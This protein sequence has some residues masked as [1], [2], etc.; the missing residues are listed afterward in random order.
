MIYALVFGL[1]III[2]GGAGFLVLDLP[3]N[4][5]TQRLRTE[6]RQLKKDNQRMRILLSQIARDD[7]GAPALEAQL[8]LGQIEEEEMVRTIDRKEL[9]R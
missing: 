5:E 8:L 2:V 1:I 6:H 3:S 4:E 7:V 9:N